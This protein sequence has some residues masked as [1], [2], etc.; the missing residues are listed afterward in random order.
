MQFRTVTVV[1][2]YSNFASLPKDLFYIFIYYFFPAFCARD[3]NRE[4]DLDFS[5]F[6]SSNNDNNKMKSNNNS[7]IK[8]FVTIFDT[9]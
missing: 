9:H 1:P 4:L 3:M 8:L 7:E 5:S 2:K 6:I